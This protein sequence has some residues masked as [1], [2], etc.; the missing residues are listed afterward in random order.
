MDG[1][2]FLMD[3]T[4]IPFPESIFDA[5]ICN[6]VL[7]LV[8]DDAQAMAELFR[9]LRRGGW[10]ILQVAISPSLD[11]T[12]EDVSITD[13]SERER[14]FG[15]CAAVRIYAMDYLDRLRQS[16]FAVNPFYW[17][18]NEEN[19]GGERNRFGLCERE[20]VFFVT[21]PSCSSDALRATI[22]PTSR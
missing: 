5:I 13:P 1:V 4:K 19:Y 20:M 8:P 16:G 11:A 3:V 10:A 7:Q 15:H 9:V 18:E 12:Y 2:D 14:L 17:Y 21:R 22:I 6:H